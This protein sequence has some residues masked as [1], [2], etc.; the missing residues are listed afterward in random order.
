MNSEADFCWNVTFADGRIAGQTLKAHLLSTT[1]PTIYS[2]TS[3]YLLIPPACLA[4][5]YTLLLRLLQMLRNSWRWRADDSITPFAL[6][7]SLLN[8]AARG[9]YAI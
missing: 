2:L 9:V 6:L 5:L 4:Y 3:C 7:I 1:R 8:Y